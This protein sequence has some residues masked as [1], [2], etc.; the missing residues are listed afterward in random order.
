[1]RF[2]L[3]AL[4]CL[5][6]SSA[7]PIVGA[8]DGP[9]PFI[10]CDRSPGEVVSVLLVYPQWFAWQLLTR[11]GEVAGKLKCT[12]YEMAFLC[13]NESFPGQVSL[14]RTNPTNAHG[15]FSP[16]YELFAPGV[17][18]PFGCKNGEAYEHVFWTNGYHKD[19]CVPIQNMIFPTHP[20]S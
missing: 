6:L 8:D 1:M 4:A 5:G 19:R 20:G 13:S 9:P 10:P 7:L 2:A 14:T 3:L 11:T 15:H 17:P 12:A 18:N 16:C